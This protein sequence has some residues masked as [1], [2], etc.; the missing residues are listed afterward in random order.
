[1]VNNQIYV[2]SGVTFKRLKNG[3]VYWFLIKDQ[4]GDTWEFPKVIARKGESSVR[5]TLRML[6][7]QAG[8][9]CRVLDEMGRTNGYSQVNGK[10]VPKRILYYLV[11]NKSQGEALGFAESTWLEYAKASRKLSS[12]KEK[13][14]LKVARD[15]QKSWQKNLKKAN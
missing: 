11:Y 3:K 7:E 2:G 5:A 8:M 1:M 13:D 14:V 10:S 6:G 4:D 9:G 12:K 15:Y